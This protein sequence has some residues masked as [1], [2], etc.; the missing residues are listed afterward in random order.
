MNEKFGTL[1]T[2]DASLLNTGD[3][4]LFSTNAWYSNILKHLIDSKYS[5]VAIFLR[6]PKKWLGNSSKLEE[7]CDYILESGEEIVINSDTGKSCLKLGVQL[8]K[9]S[10]VFKRYS[11]GAGNMFYRKLII[12]DKKIKRNLRKN[13]RCAYENVKNRPYDVNPI[14]WLVGYFELN[15]DIYSSEQKSWYVPS[16]IQYYLDK[17]Y[18]KTSSFWCSSLLT[19][20]FVECK[21]VPKNIPW[22]L[23][24]PTD[25]GNYIKRDEY[26]VM[27]DEISHD[28]HENRHEVHK[29]KMIPFMGCYLDNIIQI[30]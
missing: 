22:M 16:F 24:S 21:M 11:D 2:F 4:I 8:T 7:G 12:T 18:H 27:F 9:F 19:Y 17:Y 15:K 20:V 30:C 13:I 26:D 10:D 5:H 6:N 23:V 29:N 28:V 25:Y 1:G 3:V 14:D